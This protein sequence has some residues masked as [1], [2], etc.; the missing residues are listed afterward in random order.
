MDSPNA[1]VQEH[2]SR[3]RAVIEA[4][5]EYPEDGYSG[6]G[7]VLCAGGVKYFTCAWVC[8]RML[9]HVGCLLP[10][11]LWHLG[12]EEMSLDMTGLMRDLGVTCVDALEVRKR[13]PARILNGWEVKPFAIIHSRFAE[14][15]YLDADNVPVV[16]PE[17]LFQTPE[18]AS[19]GAVFWPDYGRLDSTRSIWAICEVPYRDESEFESGEMVLDKR[20]SWQA[21]QL[22]MHY[23]EYSDFY[24]KHIHGDKETFHMAWRR[25]GRPYAMP[26]RGIESLSGIMCQH[27]F[28]GR[29]IFQHRNS[30]KWTLAGPNPTTEGFL[31]EQEC[32]SFLEDLRGR[33]RPSTDL[34]PAPSC[35][36]KTP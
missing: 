29:R 30:R 5:T 8:I 19:T 17:F 6:R 9:R 2:Q 1:E 33:W 13:H 28:Q 32:L 7:I 21:L 34:S 23:N 24:Y 16:N 12:P 10:I 31:F 36:E 15:L 11:E 26:S 25:L 3:A 35:C 22:A 14:V 18:Y 20:R 27:D 4:I